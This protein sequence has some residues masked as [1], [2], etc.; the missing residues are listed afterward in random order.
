MDIM[1][2][3]LSLALVIATFLGFCLAHY[4]WEAGF[5]KGSAKYWHKQAMIY[6]DAYFETSKELSDLKEAQR[7]EQACKV[8][9]GR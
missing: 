7:T 5:Y 1:P 4:H 3:L 6:M 2:I 8:H 9:H